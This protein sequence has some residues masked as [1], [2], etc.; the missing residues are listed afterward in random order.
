MVRLDV[1]TDS[2]VYLQLLVFLIQLST[3]DVSI[4]CINDEIL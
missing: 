2:K 4:D 3:D 1:A